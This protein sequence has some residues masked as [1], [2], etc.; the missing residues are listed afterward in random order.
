MH[1]TLIV[2]NLPHLEEFYRINLH[3]WVGCE[4]ISCEDA[5]FA[6][7][8]LNKHPEINLIITKAKIKTEKTLDALTDYLK[9]S[10]RDCNIIII[11][12]SLYSKEK[13][14]HIPS[15]LD[16]KVLVQAAARALNVTAKEMAQK[17]VPDFFPIP[18]TLFLS[19]EE[20]NCQVYIEQGEKYIEVF[21]A[22]TPFEPSTL[23]GLINKNTELLY[24]K[25]DDRLKF[26]S[27]YNEEIACQIELV[28]LNT[29]E[30][31]N[32][33]ELSQE[34]LQKKIAKL[35]INQKTIALAQRNLV[36]MSQA[37][38]KAPSIMHLLKKLLEN[39]SGY[40]FKHSQ[41]LMFVSTHLMDNLDWGTDEQ[42]VKLQFISFFHDI[43]LEDDIQAMIHSESDLKKADVTLEEKEHVKKHAQLAA[44]IVSQ[45]PNAPIGVEQI[46]KQHHGSINGIGFSEHYSQN[47]SPMAIVFVLAEDFV[48]ALI[49]SGEKFDV[50]TQIHK[51]KEKYS[52]QRFRKILEVLESITI[53]P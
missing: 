50:K 26:T 48:D 35:G 30:V 21:S 24:V 20:S 13:Y 9:E 2:E 29:N 31:F 6:I 38:K 33:L 53:Q 16:A 39:K 40:Q 12:D 23:T 4:V 18:A 25:K 7:E 14:T 22:H 32:A 41:I 36:G 52:T 10:Q 3:T 47:I 49:Q 27:F 46:I 1:T 17:V 43:A 19:L 37:A 45:Y 51:M 44:T 11:G 28:K 34:S 15:G 5:K 8:I 42:R